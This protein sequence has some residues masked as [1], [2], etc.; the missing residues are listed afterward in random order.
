MVKK[1]SIPERWRSLRSVGLRVPGSRFIAFKVPLKGAT[2]Q[3]VTQNQKFTPKD[4][5]TA[6][7]TQNEE[8]GLIIDLTNTERYYTTKDLPK[9]ILY[10]KLHTAGLKIPDD[11]TIH[12]FKRVVR[13]FL[14]A[15]GDNDKL[16]GVH[17]TTGINRT[18]YLICRFLIDVEGWNPL[19]AITAFAQARGHAIEGAVYSEDLIKGPQRSNVG[20]DLPPTAEERMAPDN[21]LFNPQDD[22][23]RDNG[24]RDRR[25]RSLLE[26]IP[27]DEFGDFDAREPRPLPL[28]RARSGDYPEDIRDFFNARP[29][30]RDGWLPQR[31]MMDD[32]DLYMQ[33]EHRNRYFA[34]GLPEHLVSERLR[35][36]ADFNVGG[37]FNPELENRQDFLGTGPRPLM[38]IGDNY[39]LR[40]M[41]EMDFADRV[42]GRSS[43]HPREF[44]QE[45][46]YEDPSAHPLPPFARGKMN[47]AEFEMSAEHRMMAANSD[48][49]FRE[50]LR[51]QEIR[52]MDNEDPRFDPRERNLMS[53]SFRGPINERMHPRDVRAM[54]G[55]TIETRNAQLMD[56]PSNEMMH[57]R[58]IRAMEGP[59]NNRMHP[60]DARLMEGPM[61]ERMNQRV[62]PFIEGPMANRMNQRDGLVIEDPGNERLAQRDPRA[63]KSLMNERIYPRDLQAMEGPMNERM[64][65]RDG[66]SMAGTMNE[67]MQQRNAQFMEGPIND[68]MNPRNAREMEGPMNERMHQRVAQ[69]MELP[70][71]ERM[72]PREGRPMEGPMNQ[73]MPLMDARA[74]NHPMNDRLPLRDART[75]EGPMSERMHPRDA[76][77]MEGTM[78]ERMHPR[79]ALAME[80]SMNDRMNQRDAI[81]MEGA[82][83]ERMHPRD[84]RT[85]G[86]PM[87]ELMHPRDA[88][89]MEDPINERVHPHGPEFPMN[90]QRTMDGPMHGDF[91][92]DTRPFEGR[93][94]NPSEVPVRGG[95][96]FAPYPSLMQPMQPPELLR[97]PPRLDNRDPRDMLPQQQGFGFPPRNRFN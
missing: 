78:N 28:M 91:V 45:M 15:N 47:N 59:M 86:G 31:E 90:K 43:F 17:C 67:R 3:R 35:R 94:V 52:R 30:F 82:M 93:K 64:H 92:N 18:G 51:Q 60:R 66:G 4:L 61:N 79:A 75:M 46:Q 2:N 56:E 84:I 42:R 88:Q 89:A 54:E 1:N 80:G 20:I 10:V 81:A 5:V 73:R 70:L 27:G 23:A 19:Q 97:G 58:D 83:K 12:Q 39:K 57:P 13:R 41:Q 26:L 11:A 29:E 16:I 32:R 37:K 74:M 9:T 40:E 76:R 72:N 24:L 87:N 63:I 44:P 50:R 53:G 85:L 95:N 22:F 65:P 21:G 49:V 36:Q 62:E 25:L 69:L 7:R 6:I 77:F 33:F 68:Q 71:N 48:I 38:E 8:L 96:R 14:A 55:P 34:D